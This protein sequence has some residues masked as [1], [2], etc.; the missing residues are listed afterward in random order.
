MKKN[1]KN[2]YW[3]YPIFFQKIDNKKRM[4]GTISNTL[5]IIVNIN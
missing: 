4:W 1:I 5:S 3:L 2:C